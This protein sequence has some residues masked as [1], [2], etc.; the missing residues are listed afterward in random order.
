[1]GPIAPVIVIVIIIM[2]PSRRGTAEGDARRRRGE[3]SRGREGY[4]YVRLDVH[5]R[6]L[7]RDDDDLRD[8]DV[9]ARARGIRET[10][11]AR[12]RG[13]IDG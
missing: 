3:R 9:D 11:R 5:H 1:M 13:S 6:R 2:N 8:D 10:D 12:A 4:E 7:Y